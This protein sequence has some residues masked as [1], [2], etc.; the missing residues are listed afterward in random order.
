VGVEIDL[1]VEGASGM[2]HRVATAGSASQVWVPLTATQ[3]LRV[4]NTATGGTVDI[5]VLAFYE[6][7]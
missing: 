1:D 2:A 6:E 4:R 7:R 5:S 3:S